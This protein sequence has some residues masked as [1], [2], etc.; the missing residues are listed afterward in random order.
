M[1]D[2]DASTGCNLMHKDILEKWQVSI[3]L[4]TQILGAHVG[5]IM[6]LC[7]DR[8]Y[9]HTVSNTSNSPYKVGE[10][11]SIWGSGL[12]CERVLSTNQMLI[13]ENARITTE[14]DHNPDLQFDLVSYLGFPIHYPDGSL[15][16]TICILN[17]IETRFSSVMS[18]LM[19]QFRNQIESELRIEDLLRKDAARLELMEIQNRLYELITFNTSDV[20]WVLNVMQKK[21]SYVS[22]S[23]FQLRG[24][25]VE[26]ALSEPL[27]S[28]M[29]PESAA[30]VNSMIANSI[31]AFIKDKVQRAYT[32]N[33]I[34]QPRKDGQIIWVEV[35]TRYAMSE[36]GEI[37]IIGISRNIEDRKK[38]E[39]EIEYLSTHDHLTKLYNRSYIEAEAEREISRAIRYQNAISFLMIDIDLFKQINDRHGHLIGDEVLQTL[40]TTFALA[41][42]KTDICA[43]FGGEE[44][45]I[46]LPETRLEGAIGTAEKLRRTIEATVFPNNIRLTISIGISEYKLGETLD[47]LIRNADKA[48]YTAKRKGRNQVIAYKS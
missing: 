46:L 2:F 18:Q 32:V 13:V 15:F 23:I 42:R 37:E 9:V 12:Y 28:S 41:L 21:F 26:E 25:T 45:V 3:D 22:P 48:L 11:E 17:N 31:G 5:L 19:E 1:N 33:E 24:L 27:E 44:F 34:Q 43:R 8:L 40:A 4:V 14:W 29:T 35:T 38:K 16:G 36:Q 20:I 47:D 6:Q 30:K 10:S 39:N 7:G